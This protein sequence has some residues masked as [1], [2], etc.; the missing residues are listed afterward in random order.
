MQG[1]IYLRK[2][3]ADAE[4][5]ALGQ[6]ETLSRHRRILLE[7]AARKE[8]EVRGIYQELVSGESISARP[9]MQQLLRSVEQGLCGC[10]LVMEIERLARGDTMD[11]G[12]V[13]QTFKYAGALIITP[14]RTFDPGNP[15]DE[16][17]F[18][19]G[20]FMSRREYKTINRRL[21]AGRLAASREGQ[22]LGSRPPYGYDK[23]RLE[24][25]VRHT[26]V[27]N[28]D[29]ARTVRLIYRLYLEGIPGRAGQAGYGS[30]AG[31]LDAAGIPP[32]EGGEHWSPATIA[33]IL[34]NP[35]YTGR[36]KWYA[37]P[38]VKTMSG[39][40]LTTSRPRAAAGKMILADGLHEALIDPADWEAAQRRAQAAPPVPGPR[41]L[42]NPLAG[43]IF[44]SRCGRRM[45]RRPCTGGG[46]RP[47]LICPGLRCPTVSA[48]LDLVEE[49]LIGALAGFFCACELGEE[50]PDPD[51]PPDPEEEL[52]RLR[53][54]AARLAA[55]QDRLCEL[56]ERGLYDPELFQRRSGA[57]A[58]RI[59]ENEA[60]L[61]ALEREV[62]GSRAQNSREPVAP[63][64]RSLLEVYRFAKT[65]REKNEL[66]RRLLQKAVYTKE[67]G[68]RGR[69][70]S[71]TLLLYPRF[72]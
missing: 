30:I 39:G 22:Y 40:V 27:P 8:I 3:R 61:R 41:V 29:E 64:V 42:Q 70:D 20:L 53:R 59:R 15:L 60:A 5:E 48:P 31:Y 14:T 54:G 32:A 51:A 68:G 65:P 56:L 18:E 11:Q 35:V 23:A 47:A 44:C 49:R 52:A 6:G 43:L 4:L 36:I 7:L 25:P 50:P 58:A 2:S 46:G 57:L 9:A 12:V 45:L 55:Q 69:E 24:R 63:P 10:V 21:Q 34:H 62:T 38:A 16:E 19:F 13:A 37:R 67:A 1:I 28:P 26:L 33:G 66:L 72:C 71:F 17:Y